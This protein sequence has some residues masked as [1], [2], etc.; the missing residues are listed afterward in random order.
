MA[1]RYNNGEIVAIDRLTVGCPKVEKNRITVEYKVTKKKDT[2]TNELIYKWEEPVFEVDDLA[3]LNLASVIG[4]QVALNY[5]LF[6]REIL[7]E[8][9]FDEADRR[10][11]DEAIRNTAREIYVNKLLLDNPFLRLRTAEPAWDR[12]QNAHLAEV[13][14]Q[15]SNAVERTEWTVDRDRVAILSSGGKDS[16]L[17]YGLMQECGKEVHPI[18]CNESG[19]H[20][21]TALNAYRSFQQ[22]IPHTARVWMN[23]DRMFSWMLRQLPFIRQDFAS[24]RSDG[25]PIRLWTVAV[26][27]FGALPLLRKRGIGRLLIGNEYDTTMRGRHRGISH[28]CGLYDQSRFF[29]EY[30]TRYANRKG[31]R[32][33][34]FSVLRS[35]SELL[36]QKILVERYPDLQVHQVSCHAAHIEGQRVYPCGA[37]EKCR[38]II[39]MLVGLGKDP[40]RCGFKDDQVALG[41]KMIGEHYLHHERALNEQLLHMLSAQGHITKESR[42]YKNG[43]P[44]DEVFFLRFD[45]E[46]SPLDAVPTDIRQ[47]LYKIFL[48]H[49]KG[50]KRRNGNLWM[51]FNP[52][53]AES[54]SLPYRFE[55]PVIKGRKNRKDNGRTRAFLLGELTWPEARARLK[56]TDIALLPVGAIEQHGRHLPLDLDA[57]DADRLCRQV[58]AACHTPHPLV[59]PLVPYGVS[60]HHEGFSGTVAISPSTL[61]QL[62][63]EIGIS[64]ARQGITKLLVVNGH[65]GNSPALHF[66]AQM[67]NRDAQIFTCVDTGETS[68]FEIDELISSKN[69]VHAGEIETST[70]LATRS[71]L[72]KMELA[73]RSIPR[74]SSEYLEFSSRKRVDWYV[75]TARLSKSGVLG[76][77]TKA[78]AEKGQ[79]IWKIMIRNLVELVEDLKN[80]A[81]DEIF[82]RKY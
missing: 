9:I 48:E 57:Y 63:Y 23:S 32:I 31:W 27:L 62:V 65:G 75:H 64:V 11:I 22:N 41:L 6:C 1:S 7:F 67:I 74:F 73:K 45:A 18:F 16:L 66:A 80:L 82:Q 44:H 21:Y 68:D 10:F 35:L 59:L 29:D 50:G 81:L 8:G 28:Y 5:G 26:F 38:R 70:A 77:P 24:V 2:E 40:A 30:I 37:C 17:T 36:I 76:D 53:S 60:Y 52:L 58:A 71:H 14:Y 79:K 46:K 13:L 69:D 51:E 42:L 49:A 43:R 4:A 3:S 33:N 61:S 54:L 47:P 72:V 20:W 34:Q 19:R 55:G 15:N 25:Y 39:G 56:E 12:F 78:S